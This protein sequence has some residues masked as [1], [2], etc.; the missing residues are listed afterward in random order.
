MINVFLRAFRELPASLL[1]TSFGIEQYFVVAYHIC[2]A[3]ESAKTAAYGMV[4]I[5]FMTIVVL[6]V[7]RLVGRR[8]FLQVFLGFRIRPF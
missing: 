7:Q 6:A 3:G 2:S 5:V 1:L 8:Y 4:A